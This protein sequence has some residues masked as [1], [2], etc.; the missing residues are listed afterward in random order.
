MATVHWKDAKQQLQAAHPTNSQRYHSFCWTSLR[1]HAVSGS[2]EHKAK[3]HKW[4][5]HAATVR[6][7]LLS[8]PAP[9]VANLQDFG[10]NTRHQL[11]HAYAVH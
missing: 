9:Q 5:R 3:S 4:L 7:N 1:W 2:K 10:T 6:G 11:Q 8:T